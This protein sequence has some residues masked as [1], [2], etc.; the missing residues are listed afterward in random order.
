MKRL[1]GTL[2]LLVLL[3]MP[4]G[5]AAAGPLLDLTGG[6]AG[7]VV[8]AHQASWGFTLSSPIAVGALGLWDEGANGLQNGHQLGL[9][10]S[11]G[12]LLASTLITTANSTPVA[13]S[14]TAG[15][16]RFTPISPLTLGPGDYVLGATFRNL[17]DVD[18]FRDGAGSALLLSFIPGASF[19]GADDAVALFANQQQVPLQFPGLLSGDPSA[20]KL[21]ANLLVIEAAGVPEPSSLLVLGSGLAGL[22]G[23]RWRRH[24]RK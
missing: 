3:L 15:D 16:W 8:N 10:A 21:G 7:F 14:S 4:G 1:I 19:V 22:A 13:S 20:A 18:L 12:S 6:H 11:D 9:W 17:G 2:A 24:R 5:W 23:L